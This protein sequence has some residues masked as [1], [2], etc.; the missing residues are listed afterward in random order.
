MEKDFYKLS[1]KGKKMQLLGKWLKKYKQN[2]QRTRNEK[3]LNV[4]NN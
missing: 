2:T 4:S 1:W 3:P